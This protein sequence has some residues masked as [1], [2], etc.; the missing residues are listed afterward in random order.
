MHDGRCRLES[1]LYSLVLN[2]SKGGAVESLKVR[3]LQDRELVDWGNGRSFNELRG[4]FIEKNSFCLVPNS[5]LR[6]G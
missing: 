5:L 4:F 2:P 3:F 6:F 1:D